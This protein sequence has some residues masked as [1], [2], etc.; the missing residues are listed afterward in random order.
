MKKNIGKIDSAIRIVLAIILLYF[1]EDQSQD[2]QL[3]FAVVAA[4]LI[5]T[6]LNGFC[7]LYK[8]FGLST[9]KSKDV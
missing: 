1:M 8:P 5:F 7:L 2:I 9:R 3:L 6:A 4:A